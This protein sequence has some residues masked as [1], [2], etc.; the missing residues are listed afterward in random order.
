MSIHK[1]L[2]L[3]HAAPQFR[4]G[5]FHRALGSDQILGRHLLPLLSREQQAL[6]VSLLS[7]GAAQLGG[8]GF[9]GFFPD[10]FRIFQGQ[11]ARLVAR[12]LG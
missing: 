10:R 11:I 3:A 12:L 9:A 5:G 7:Q 8:Y 6:R 1:A 4:G 2:Q